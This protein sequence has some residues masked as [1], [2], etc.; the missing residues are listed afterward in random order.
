MGFAAVGFAAAGTVESFSFLLNACDR[1]DRKKGSTLDNSSG[2][3]AV[4]PGQSINDMQASP[5]AG[6]QACPHCA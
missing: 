1:G 3:S 4:A 5:T 2:A 6:V